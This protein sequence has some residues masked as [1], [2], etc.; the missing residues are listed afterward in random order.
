MVSQ[1]KT[2]IALD[3]DGVVNKRDF[4]HLY[5]MCLETTRTEIVSA[6]PTITPSFFTN[7]GLPQPHKINANN[8]KRK[9][10]AY[11]VDMSKKNDVVFYV[12]NEQEYLAVA[13]ILGI[14]TYIY[15]HGKI[16]KFTMKTK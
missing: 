14:H 4:E 6:N 9:K 10:L 15:K 12:D 1:L 11:L 8:G 13:W 5:K 2:A 16:T 3:F 7:R